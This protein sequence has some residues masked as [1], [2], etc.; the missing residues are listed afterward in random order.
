MSW[1]AQFVSHSLA[2]KGTCTVLEA[3][4]DPVHTLIAH[5]QG[6]GIPCML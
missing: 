6:I 1:L 5:G 2:G 4:S 3:G